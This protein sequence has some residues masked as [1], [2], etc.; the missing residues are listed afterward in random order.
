MLSMHGAQNCPASA[1][2]A[3]GI[4]RRDTIPPRNYKPIPD[5]LT[6]PDRG[7][8]DPPGARVVWEPAGSARLIH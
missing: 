6:K 3:T 7:D 4:F 8:T 2:P 5:K 1:S